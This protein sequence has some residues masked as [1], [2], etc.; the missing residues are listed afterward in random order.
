MAYDEITLRKIYDR[1]DGRCH[2]CLKKLS[3]IN[4]GKRGKRGAWEVDHSCPRS[5]NGGDRLNNLYASCIFCNRTKGTFSS[6]TARS[7]HGRTK[8]PL[9]RA[10]KER[11]KYT[12]AMFGGIA[13]LILGL[14]ISP[15]IALVGSIVGGKIGYDIDPD[16]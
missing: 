12:N 8:A 4:Y 3:F 11:V 15:F 14:Y 9:T 6:K 7:W 16:K 5:M 10:K 2:I 13:G 1:T